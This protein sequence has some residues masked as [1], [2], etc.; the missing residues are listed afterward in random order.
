MARMRR[1]GIWVGLACLCAVIG[2]LV[3]RLADHSGR[4][5]APPP[6][7]EPAA[8]ETA[9]SSP[10]PTRSVTGQAFG[11]RRL[12]VNTGGL[13]AE[14]CLRFSDP[15][16]RRPNVHYA[17][18]LALT[19]AAS[20]SVR[21][22][23]HDLCL[24]GLAFGTSYSLTLRQGL[25]AA[26]GARLP[27]DV[28]LPV[29]LA[30][31]APMVSIAGDA[32]LLSRRTATGLVI[33]T[34]NVSRVRIHVLRI[35]PALLTQAI[36][37]GSAVDIN[38]ASTQTVTYQLNSLLQT[39]ASVIW[40][41]TLDV[42]SDHNRTVE[43]AF[44]LGD[45][46]KAQTQ[47][48]YLVIAENAG[49]ALPEQ[50]FSPRP[51]TD[52]RDIGYHTLPSHWVVV[53]DL[54]LTTM[55]GRDGLHV[56]ARSFAS[57]LPQPGVRLAL[58]SNGQE[59][60]AAATTDA[61]G[62]AAFP[63]GLLAG[64][65]ANAPAA[66]SA[67]A[68]DDFALLDLQR[69]AFDFSDRGVSGRP[70]AGPLEAFLTTERGIY[71]PGETLNVVAL[72]RDAR[73]LG[74]PPGR[75][76]LI[77]R[78][79]DGVEARRVSADTTMDGGLHATFTL[80]R[81]S[82]R[83]AWS[84]EARLDPNGAAIGRADFQVQDFVPQQL[85]VTLTTPT[86]LLVSGE[87]LQASLDG[88][89][90]Y[91]AP[92]AGLNAEAELRTLR[93]PDPVPAAPGYQFG[94]VDEQVTQTSQPIVVPAADDKG[95]SSFA[96]SYAPAQPASQTVPIEAVLRAGMFEPSGR[97][98]ND[99]VTLKLQTQ[100]LLIGLRS[101]GGDT[102]AAIG[103]GTTAASFQIRSFSAAGAPVAQTGLHW[104]IVRE[105]EVYDWF[106]T[107]GNDWSVH[108]HVIDEP[109]RNGA[110][111]TLADQPTLLSANLDWG[112]YRLVVSDPRTSAASSLRVTVGWAENAGGPDTPDKVR[113]TT[114]TPVLA[115]G[116]STRI[117]IQGPFAGQAL[118][119]I[120]GDRVFETHA[121]A[122]PATGAD[123]TL[124][125][126]P[127]WGP[128]AYALVSMYRPLNQPAPRHAPVRAVGLVW[129]ALD[130][131]PHRLSVALHAPA[132]MVPRHR[133][134]VAIHV[135]G[136]AARQGG[137]VSLAAVDEGILQLTR[138]A[139]PDPLDFLWGKR[140]LG[141]DMRDQY[142]RLMDADAAAGAI[143]EGGDAA[144]GGEGL[145]V[146]STRIVSLF[147]GPVAFDR[148]G[149]ASVTLD[150]PDF[151]GRLRL[152]AVAWNSAAVGAA[153]SA[154]IVRDPTF[155]DIALPRFLAPGDHASVAVSVANTDGPA[156]AYHLSLNATGAAAIEGPATTDL[157]LPAGARR[158]LTVGLTGTDAGIGT[159]TADL[160]G[161]H[162]YRLHRAWQI[163]VRPGH[164]PLTLS[165]TAQQMPGDSFSV[166]PRQLDAFVPGSLSVSVGYSGYAGIDTVGLL[167]ALDRYPFGCTEQL[168]STAWPLL[169]FNDPAL[170]GRL[171]QDHS[172]LARV[173]EAIDS[174]ID[175]EDPAGR[176]GLWEVGDGQASPWLDAYAVEFLLHAR[177]AHFQVPQ[178]A[179]DRALAW[180]AE[181]SQ[182]SLDEY[183]SA[184][185]PTAEQSRAYALYVLAQAGRG[186]LATMRRMHDTAAVEGDG[187]GLH[188]R[189]V[190]WGQQ[191]GTDNLAEPLAL[192]QLAGALALSGDRARAHDAF[193][194]AVGSL[195]SASWG[196]P[197]W[198]DFTY[199]SYVRDLAGLTAIAADSGENDLAQSLIDRFGQLSLS[200]PA[201]NTQEQAALLG[202]AHAMNRDAPGR[203]LMVNGTLIQP[204]KLPAAFTPEAAAI[205]AG[206][207]LRNTG[208]VPLW[209]T[210]TVT[211]VPAQSPPA[212]SAGYTLD[213]QYLTLDGQPVDIAHMRQNDRFIVVL[214]GATQ[215]TDNHRTVLVDMLPAGWE[216]EAPISD[217]DRYPF[218]G[219]LT[220]TRVSEARDDRFV[221][222]FDIGADFGGMRFHMVN[223]SA[224]GAATAMDAYE[225][226]VAYLARVI[227]PGRFLQ[228]EASVEDMYRPQELARTE[229]GE[230]VAV[231]R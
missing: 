227:T 169:S 208:S 39:A 124:T 195:G 186:D 27:A 112:T 11:F 97:I 182:Q 93:D 152:M 226:R 10:T 153:D 5:L 178:P 138:Y 140:R 109:F 61:T 218:L 30:D 204:L 135:T 121:L 161:P 50:S 125:A 80:T 53:T 1:S 101:P 120:A 217:A 52:Y 75:L 162:R 40:T 198:F 193:A 111:D 148:D 154:V 225:F 175:R 76:T 82:A 220:Q 106:S 51:Q 139:T 45:V 128:G 102:L 35:S 185:G 47:G 157:T 117:H 123:L 142:G 107:N 36:T 194:E 129:L 63:P 41:G 145:P 184:F 119:T 211:G 223:D 15:L 189:L 4:L 118:V 171:P 176:F 26:S 92:A 98:V 49:R 122:V 28:T 131:A 229:S 192:G 74:A 104:A 12:I 207:S 94:L 87:P 68:G 230:T 67:V 167:Q 24:G 188:P 66:V 137:W 174:I 156:G 59:V 79:P 190:Y 23:G 21:V 132:Q 165:Q 113:V 116:Q 31:R 166:D 19:P 114:E 210:L 187:S 34:V 164:Y 83:G 134:T 2:L 144:I 231:P 127:A 183:D 181:E 6:V 42:A 168:V 173:Q 77:L 55:S 18:Y 212:L 65:G 115:A 48:A 16:D 58:L 180:L 146:T 160:S 96:V 126:D 88:A 228:P 205:R 151:E 179:L 108:Y 72:L 133:V 57:A 197:G 84:V 56:F 33:Q 147:G 3:W 17:D 206:Y 196:P 9:S 215:D 13:L 170:L 224:P 32:Y 201:L 60:L 44:P 172:A 213:R 105:N 7:A 216:I 62:A 25:P 89:F 149:D 143:R 14:A 158:A 103:E 70:T 37:G 200:P 85:K 203:A 202:A 38:L 46:I 130:P 214:H 95:H 141:I 69:G 90:L 8:S 221:A 78:R 177:A 99:T 159:V 155:A 86:K 100:P 110:I 191:L 71:R 136:A 29:S 163:A 81:T 222:A 64:Q 22:D 209:R 73:G 43:T 150:V 20:T 54:A 199:W 91:G 219:A